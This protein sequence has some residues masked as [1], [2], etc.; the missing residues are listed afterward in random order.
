MIS[1]EASLVLRG[2]VIAAQ[3][4]SLAGHRVEKAS[5]FSD[6]PSDTS[7]MRPA[8]SLEDIRDIAR[9]KGYQEGW[10][11]GHRLATAKAREE[12]LVQAQALI[13]AA[14]DD[15]RQ[16]AQ[17]QAAQRAEESARKREVEQR[18]RIDALTAALVT[19]ITIRLE[20]AEDDLLALCTEAVVRLLGAAAVHPVAIQGAVTQALAAVRSRQLVSVAMHASDLKALQAL[21][22][23]DEWQRQH[24][25]QV[26]WVASAEV[27][28][29]GCLIHSPEGSLDARLDTQL[30]MFTRLLLESRESLRTATLRQQAS[31]EHPQ[32]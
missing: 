9:Q 4:V 17:T 7:A 16:A 26:Q 32:P 13:A 14:A 15:A 22:D 20:A 31:A 23:W 27:S 25:P 24:A 8:D 5:R 28:T 19:E 10:E 2:V 18:S 21:P 12:V 29:G 1:S 30:Q 11:E 6:V 3:P